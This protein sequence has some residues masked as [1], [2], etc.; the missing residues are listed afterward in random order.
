[1]EDYEAL[2][3][4]GRVEALAALQDRWQAGYRIRCSQGA[5]ED[6]WIAERRDNADT[7]L[8]H[9]AADLAVKIRMDLLLRPLAE[10]SHG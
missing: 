5:I 4:A 8:A 7:L 1:M 10:A 6:E 9:T 2:P 3:G